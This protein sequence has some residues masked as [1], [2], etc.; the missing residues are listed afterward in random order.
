MKKIFE[1]TNNEIPKNSVEITTPQLNIGIGR[2]ISISKKLSLKS[3]ISFNTTFDGKR[4]SLLKLGFINIYPQA[5]LELGISNTLFIR[6]GVKN[7]Q[8]SPNFISKD[9]TDNYFSDKRLDFVPSVGLGFHYKGFVFDYA[10]T[11]FIGSSSDFYSHI[12]SIG[13]K[14]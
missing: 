8:I 11:N 5:G 2:Y 7:F 13:L 12:V 6:S 3:E 9:T 10:F 14:F 1:Q 4:N